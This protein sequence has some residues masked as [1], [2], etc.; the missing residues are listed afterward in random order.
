MS[1]YGAEYNE[2]ETGNGGATTQGGYASHIRANEYFVF[3]IPDAIETKDAAPMMYV[4][5]TYFLDKHN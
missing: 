2:Y 1:R 5:C 4:S 3:P